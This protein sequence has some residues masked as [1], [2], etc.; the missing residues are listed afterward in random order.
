MSRG[1]DPS[2]FM[3]VKRIGSWFGMYESRCS[4]SGRRPLRNHDARS[5]PPEVEQSGAVIIRIDCPLGVRTA[6]CRPVQRNR[7]VTAEHAGTTREGCVRRPGLD[8]R[9]HPEPASRNRATPTARSA[10]LS[11]MSGVIRRAT[12]AVVRTGATLTRLELV[13]LPLD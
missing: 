9:D 2:A 4:K 5:G 11:R 10:R 12:P 3:S 8:G 7:C 1:V 13:R 6:T